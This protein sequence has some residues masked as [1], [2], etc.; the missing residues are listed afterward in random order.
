M[1]D[2]MFTSLLTP[3][4]LKT[5]RCGIERSDTPSEGTPDLRCPRATAELHKLTIDRRVIERDFQSTQDLPAEQ[6]IKYQLMYQLSRITRLRGLSGMTTAGRP[7]HGL[8]VAL[9]FYG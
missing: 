2:G 4:L 7:E 1:G 3:V 8:P 9:G 6:A 5:Y